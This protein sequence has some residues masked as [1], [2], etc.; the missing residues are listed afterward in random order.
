MSFHHPTMERINYSL[1]LHL[2]FHLLFPE[3][4][5]E[6]VCFSS[7]PLFD[8]SDHED[9]DEIIEFSDRSCRDLFTLVFDHNDDS[10][11]VNFLK[12]H[13]YDDLSVDEVET[14]Q[15][16]EA[17]QPELMVMVGPRFL[18]VGF[19]SDHE[20]VQTLKAP[21]HSYVCAQDQSNTHILLPPLK[22]YDPI[23]HALE[24][25]YIASTPAR[26]KLFFF[27]SIACMSQ[28]R[29]Y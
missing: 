25:S 16:V 15:T 10:I 17:L 29:V 26:C 27:L 11:A 1:K 9:A 3:T 18:E 8:S 13:V 2:T 24:E 12:P 4:Q 7:T 21:H 14:L 23:S 28:S 19:A 20:I 22:L 5:S 6:F